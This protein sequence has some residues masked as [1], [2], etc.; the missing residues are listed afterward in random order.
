MFIIVASFTLSAWTS[1]VL[2]D[3]KPNKMANYINNMLTLL[4]QEDEETDEIP[5]KC[6][7]V[8]TTF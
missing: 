5:D 2:D 4:H 8:R 6:I 1:F 7:Y 3:N